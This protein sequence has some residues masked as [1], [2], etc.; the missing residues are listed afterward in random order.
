MN[1]PKTLNL[2]FCGCGA[3]TKTH[4]REIQKIPNVRIRAWWNRTRARAESL[5]QEFGG[6]YVADDFTRLA[7]DPSL[8][9]IYINT[10]HNDRLRLLEAVARAGKPVFME[11]PLTHDA[12]SLRAMHRLLQRHP[13]LFQ[14]GYKLRFNCMVDKARQLIARPHLLMAHVFDETWPDHTGLNDPQV[15]GGNVR[16]QGV[17]A[18][19]LLHVLAGTRPVAVTGAVSRRRHASGI[20]DTLGAVFEFEGGAI[21]TIAVA[22]AGLATDGASKFFV[23]AAGDNCAYAL[24]DRFKRLEWRP[25]GAKTPEVFTGEEDGFLKQSVAFLAAVRGQ[26]KVDC[27]FIEGAIPSIMIYQAIAAAASGRRETI[28]VEKW[29]AEG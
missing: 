20:E 3:I 25:K 14:S 22:D 6:D 8:D 4:A 29:L 23:E 15:G 13:V 1:D 9:A 2:G 24:H 12:A 5:H 28:V 18:T 19:E 7:E 27:D 17:Y 10:M 26:G 11:K 21:G 16:S